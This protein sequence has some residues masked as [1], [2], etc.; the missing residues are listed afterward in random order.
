VVL[1]GTWRITGDKRPADSGDA[2]S[3]MTKATDAKN[4]AQLLT[5]PFFFVLMAS[6]GSNHQGLVGEHKVYSGG[7]L[8]DL[9][10][11]AYISVLRTSP[12]MDAMKMPYIVAR[13]VGTKRQPKKRTREPWSDTRPVCLIE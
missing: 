6:N 4:S 1:E 10:R 9:E 12:S 5:P 2:R 3:D 7:P 13:R 11:R 8:F